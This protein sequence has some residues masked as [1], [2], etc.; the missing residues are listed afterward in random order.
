[1]PVTVPLYCPAC[2]ASSCYNL[3][4]SFYLSL[5]SGLAPVVWTPTASFLDHHRVGVPI[6]TLSRCLMPLFL[7]HTQTL[8]VPF[9]PS[10]ATRTVRQATTLTPTLSSSRGYRLGLHA[11]SLSR[12]KPSSLA[13]WFAYFLSGRHPAP[14]TATVPS[15]FTGRLKYR[16]FSRNGSSARGDE[17]R[18]PGSIRGQRFTGIDGGTSPHLDLSVP[19]LPTHKRTA[20]QRRNQR[21]ATAHGLCFNPTIRLQPTNSGRARYNNNN[22]LFSSRAPGSNLICCCCIG[23][24]AYSRSLIGASLRREPILQDYT[25]ARNFTTAPVAKVHLRSRS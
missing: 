25:Q 3:S 18:R 12:L 1:M 23:L 24:P 22:Q 8:G 9:V 2:V 17:F 15:S 21:T 13:S 7:G 14:H 4:I 20:T 16:C 5:S 6:T 11:L 19:K 10:W